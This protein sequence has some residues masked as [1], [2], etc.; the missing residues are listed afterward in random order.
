MVADMAFLPPATIAGHG[1]H[2]V[3]P[4]HQG[5]GAY[6]A[7]LDDLYSRSRAQARFFDAVLPDLTIAFDTLVPDASR[8]PAGLIRPVLVTITSL[9]VDRSVRLVHRTHQPQFA[10]AAVAS[11]EPIGPVEWLGDVAHSANTSWRLNQDLIQRIGGAIGLPSRP[12]PVGEELPEYPAERSRKNLLFL[13][14]RGVL[15]DAVSKAAN[16]V[17]GSIANWPSQS[18]N[19][20]ALDLATDRYCFLRRGLLSPVGPFR[21]CPRIELTAGRPNPS[22][23]RD[24]TLTVKPIIWK[25]FQRLL[26][27]VYPSFQECESAGVSTLFSDL[28]VDWFPSGFLEAFSENVRR[29]DSA[30]DWRGLTAIIGPDLVSTRG[31]LIGTAARRRGKAVINLQHGGTYGYI[32]D[33]SLAGQT[34]YAFCDKMVTWGW[35]SI[36]GH[37]P[38]CQT[39]P[40]PAPRLSEVPLRAKYSLRPK[41]AGDIETDVL[42]VSNIFHRFPHI[43]T[44]GQSRVDFIDEIM[45]SQE[46][47]VSALVDCGLSILHKPYSARVVRLYAE[48]FQ[49][50]IHFQ[51]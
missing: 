14:Q 49:A 3:F 21:E 19:F 24:L 29:V 50:W 44:S 18:A 16:R 30:I 39:V 22:L 25:P 35:T 4:R 41:K 34:E 33:H 7:T 17:L 11:V 31:Y 10:A 26:H 2:G 42:F 36:D 27:E 5:D 28:L 1:L 12:W 13:P 48:H 38:S 46:V 8:F 15:A 47:L 32:E 40:L 51:L 20:L 9:V 6:R 45:A 37:F 43:S 23:R